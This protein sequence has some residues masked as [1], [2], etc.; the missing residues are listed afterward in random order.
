ML[1]YRNNF[2]C[3]TTCSLFGSKLPGNYSVTFFLGHKVGPPSPVWEGGK[4]LF[5]S[6]VAPLF[7]AQ[8]TTVSEETLYNVISG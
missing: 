3:V 1:Q 4:E 5:V 7:V 6:D 2:H 8:G